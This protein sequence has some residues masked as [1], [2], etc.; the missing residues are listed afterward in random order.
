MTPISCAKALP[1]GRIVPDACP[2][3]RALAA[4]LAAVFLAAC[5][6]PPVP[7]EIHDPFEV[8]NRLTHEGNK[9][10]DRAVLRP[11]A[12]AW[13]AAVP[14]PVRRGA[15]NFTGNL[16]A[17]GDIVNDILQGRPEDAVHNLFRFV[18]NSTLG[19]A[20]IFDPAQDFGL[21]ARE[22]DFG[23]TLH[24]WGAS[25]GAFL[26]L[27]L[28]GPSTERDAVGVAVDIA[29]NPA[30]LVFP[31]S[32]AST[33]ARAVDIIDL[34]QRLGGAIDALLYESAD[35]YAQ[36]RT[37]YLQNRRFELGSEPEED[38][39]DPYEDILGE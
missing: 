7:V 34:R 39:F 13:G 22:T 27:P 6:T 3:P 37:I 17:P 10:V 25:E 5:N 26:E 4:V 9:D 2:R 33:A 28:L 31:D 15:A 38:Y 35:S 19:L 24:A 8:Q 29:L 14:A 18:I 1:V 16:D 30:R 20:G 36:S 23:E 32:R 11:L 12:R 21:E